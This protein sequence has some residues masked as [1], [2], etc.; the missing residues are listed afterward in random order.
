MRKKNYL[1]IEKDKISARKKVRGCAARSWN[2][3][4]VLSQLELN[5]GLSQ[6]LYT[7]RVLYIGKAASIGCFS[8]LFLLLHGLLDVGGE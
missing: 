4:E 3:R 2:H 1:K 7:W 8:V 6:C 5:S